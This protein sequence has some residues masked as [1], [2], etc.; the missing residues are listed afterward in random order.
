M[1]SIRQRNTECPPGA[2]R[3][4]PGK[5][6]L[7]KIFKKAKKQNKKF[8]YFENGIHEEKGKTIVVDFPVTIIGA[9][10][11]RCIFRGGFTIA[12]EGEE[13]DNV[14]IT[15]LT[16][17]EAKEVGVAVAGASVQLNNV[18]VNLCEHGVVVSLSQRNTMT[19]CKISNSGYSGLAVCNGGLMTIDGDGTTIHDNC[20]DERSQNYGLDTGFIDAYTPSSIII[21][22]PLTKE[23]ISTNNGGGGNWGGEGTITEEEPPSIVGETKEEP[24]ECPPGALRVSPG[25]NALKN[26]F[27][28]AEEKGFQEIYLENGIHKIETWVDP[29]GDNQNWLQICRSLTIIGASRSKC[30]VAGS[31]YIVLEEKDE[32][33]ILKNM[34][35]RD[36]EVGVR[37]YSSKGSS[38]LDN[39]HIDRCGMGVSVS[40]SKKNSMKNCEINISEIAVSVTDD[41]SITIEG[42]KTTIHN[43]GCGLFAMK[44][45]STIKIILPITKESICINNT[46]TNW[47]GEGT[48]E[49]LSPPGH[50]RREVVSKCPPGALR[51]LPG[52]NALKNAIEEAEEKGI[53]NI[54]LE[55]GIHKIEVYQDSDGKKYN[56]VAITESS[57]TIIGAS[58]TKCI[59]IGGFVISAKKKVHV[60]IKTMT[61][62]ESLWAGVNG[63]NGSSLHLENLFIDQCGTGVFMHRLEDSTMLNCEISNSN[64]RGILVKNGK[65]T[66]TGRFNLIRNNC[67][68]GRSI[69]FG[70]HAETGADIEIQSPTTNILELMC[71]NNGGAGNYGGKG[72]IEQVFCIGKESKTPWEEPFYERQCYICKEFQNGTNTMSM[73]GGCHKIRYCG[74]VCFTK[75]WPR[76]QIICNPIRKKE[77][78]KRE[79]K[80][81]RREEK[82]KE[83]KK[84]VADAVAAVSADDAVAD[85]AKVG[86]VLID[87]RIVNES[88]NEQH[89]TLS[90]LTTKMIQVFAAYAALKDISLD[91]ISFF[92]NGTKIDSNKTPELLK[93]KK[94]DRIQAVVDVAPVVE[95]APAATP[96]NCSFCD[97]PLDLNNHKAC[98]CEAVFYC[99]ATQC[100][101][102]AWTDHKPEHRRLMKIIKKKIKRQKIV[103]DIAA[104]RKKMEEEERDEEE[105]REGETKEGSGSN[106]SVLSSP[107]CGL[108][109]SDILAL[110]EAASNKITKK[111][112]DGTVFVCQM[113][114]GKPNGYGTCTFAD[115][116]KYVGE[117]KNS[118][119]DG[120]GTETY[121]SGSKYV[122]EWKDGKTNGNGTHTWTDGQ[123]YI[124]QWKDSK[125]NGNGTKTWADGEK[126]VGEWKDD[127]RNGNGIM[128]W[129][130]GQKYI[131]EWK[132]DKQHGNGTHTWA[133]GEK[134]VGEW[135]D[136]KRNGNG[137]MTWTDGQKYVGEW[138]DNNQHG[139]GTITYA[140]G[141]KYI[142]E[143][144]DDKRNGNGTYTWATG[145]K[146]IGEWKDDNKNGNGTFTDVESRTYIGE[147]KKDKKNGNGTFTWTDGQKYIGQFKDDKRNGNGTHTWA[148]GRKYIGE[149]KDDNKNGNGTFT[150][151]NGD[152]CEGEFKDNVFHGTGTKT[153]TDG[154]KYIGQWRYNQQNGQGTFTYADG[155]TWTGEW[156]ND[157]K[158]NETR[159]T[160]L[161][162][163]LPKLT[164]T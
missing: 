102:D 127:K 50:K 63:S 161:N 111:F 25:L 105:V 6:R 51:V 99:K 146:Y 157:N 56:I 151:S 112:G 100:Q 28:E 119:K 21:K 45:S 12:I 68:H 39:L 30:I 86:D 84:L 116:T 71:T 10:R 154:R 3:V 64:T 15:D 40:Q 137:I 138:K 34:T 122:G 20:T 164:K 24:S 61:I 94:H 13:N 72:T 4:K 19:D 33:V 117:W 60:I 69:D 44:T 76:H 2:L 23:S 67:Q 153:W 123:K 31:F 131:G 88:G 57:L 149:W 142:G 106:S 65:L 80:E 16:I 140:N 143:W 11:D 135:K 159:S 108:S 81:K 89:F 85:A 78:L 110:V 77:R 148:D 9:S 158:I 133:D 136:D 29:D 32:I 41:G 109:E 132:D 22:S 134:Y 125:K 139:I 37:I 97:V 59:V 82:K 14:A 104:A 7:A 43:N 26:A 55:N 107:S 1:K 79:R 155:S 27:I 152:K 145:E 38:H 48:F 114:G 36:A 52:L 92:L 75:D 62:R 162:A 91:S 49:K 115:G 130:D 58:R 93:L 73:C 66:I 126:Y 70:L 103:D 42:D 90:Y 53:K 141:Q 120:N 87:I 144:K 46:K 74:T 54:Y 35:V 128:T 98:P 18:A 124:G 101:D 5:K 8:I 118:N 129:A 150:G 163:R 47:L 17:C 160:R 121:A 156:E 113:K 83:R 96:L 147:W 95:S